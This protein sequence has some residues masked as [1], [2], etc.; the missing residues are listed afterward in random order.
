MGRYLVIGI[1]TSIGVSKQKAENEYRRLETYKAVL[2][3]DFNKNEIYQW[4]ETED[5]FGLKLK[6]EIAE[7]EWGDFIRS[8]FELRYLDNDQEDYQ[9]NETLEAI[10]KEHDLEGWLELAK[11][12]SFYCYQRDRFCFYPINNPH[13]YYGYSCAQVEFVAL[14]YDGKILMECYDG[15]LDFFTR[16]IRERLSNYRLSDSLLVH[17]TE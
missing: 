2:E 16:I 6:P 17:I 4:I 11:Q 15:L 3:N 5:F 7:K 8:F 9:I 12:K 13:S 1:A 10:A 14:S